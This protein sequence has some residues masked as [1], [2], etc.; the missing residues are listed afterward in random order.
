MQW[1]SWL[2]L[3]ILMKIYKRKYL[4]LVSLSLRRFF[5]FLFGVESGIRNMY[6]IPY[7]TPN[8]IFSKYFMQM[9]YV[10]NFFKSWILFQLTTP[11]DCLYSGMSQGKKGIIRH[12]VI[13]LER[14]VSVSQ[15]TT[16]CLLFLIL[17]MSFMHLFLIIK[18]V[19]S[20]RKSW[21]KCMTSHFV[22]FLWVFFNMD[23]IFLKFIS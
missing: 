23:V 11:F 4:Q 3:A 18:S 16:A 5:C 14:L 19:F 13:R 2:I 7:S 6:H 22:S 1:F 15:Y 20:K 8:N 17:L 12:N 21:F 9:L 10:M